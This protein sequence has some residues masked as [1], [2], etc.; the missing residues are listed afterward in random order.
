MTRIG[1]VT[2]WGKTKLLDG[3]GPKF[4]FQVGLYG[5]HAEENRIS[6]NAAEINVSTEHLGLSGLDFSNKEGAQNGLAML[7]TAQT[8][9]SEHRSM[10]GAFQNR[11]KDDNNYCVG[12]S[13][14]VRSNSCRNCVPPVSSLSRKWQAVSA[15]RSSARVMA[16]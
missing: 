13:A 2:T 12:I 15:K 14:M 4:D 5:D 8:A 16:T 9:V 10:L 11:L 1:S 7:D 3:S 6:F